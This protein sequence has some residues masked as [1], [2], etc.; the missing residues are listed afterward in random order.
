MSLRR[1]N[2]SDN[3]RARARER[4]GVVID[5]GTRAVDMAATAHKRKSKNS[6][7]N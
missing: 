2:L 3:S 5:A 4:Y 1:L 7:N 6:V